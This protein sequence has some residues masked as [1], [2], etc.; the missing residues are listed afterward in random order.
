MPGTPAALADIAD[1][2]ITLHEEASQAMAAGLDAV[3]PTLINR[4]MKYY[5]L[6]TDPKGAL[7]RSDTPIK[8]SH[9]FSSK[10]DQFS[11][12]SVAC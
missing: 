2:R 10:F 12:S 1:Q 11:F 7:A 4:G 3:F 9:P 6:R 8:V 5:E